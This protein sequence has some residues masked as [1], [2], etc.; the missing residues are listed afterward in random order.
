MLNALS[1][2]GGMGVGAFLLIHCLGRRRKPTALWPLPM[3]FNA[4]VLVAVLSMCL[5]DLLA[6]P[7]QV[8]GLKVTGSGVFIV[9]FSTVTLW[10]AVLRYL[11]LGK[12]LRAL[13]GVGIALIIGGQ[14]LIV[15]DGTGSGGDDDDI[16]N[17]VFVAGV[18][19]IFVAAFLD[20]VMYV[21]CERFSN[22]TVDDGKGGA[23][24][25]LLTED[26]ICCLC[27]V[28]NICLAAAYVGAYSAAGMWNE[29]VEEP[30]A[31]GGARPAV[32]AAV[33]LFDSVLYYGHYAA[34]YYVAKHSSVSAG[35]NK[36]MQG[37]AIFYSSD[38]IFCRSVA[39]KE[40]RSQCL[41]TFK[42]LAS[43]GVCLG[44]LVYSIPPRAPKGAPRDENR[45]STQR[46]DRV[47][48]DAQL[49]AADIT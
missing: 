12:G 9:V 3:L 17:T 27:G 29:W 14:L 11:A 42:V 26:E 24:A 36:A 7:F 23:V 20:A 49:I 43:L 13:Q 4:R 21:F 38:I 32:V 30:V 46:D 35:V 18:V 44:V 33:W 37:A 25:R 34:F 19:S 31:R 5:P 8:Y 28:V 48:D 41:T 16:S 40:R 47:L 10:V 15:K 22:A 6:V 45:L 2:Y 1:Q 39:V